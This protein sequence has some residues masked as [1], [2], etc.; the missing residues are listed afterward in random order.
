M[1]KSVNDDVVQ[2]EAREGARRA[3]SA[4]NSITLRVRIENKVG[5]IGEVIS[6]IGRAGGDVGAIDIVQVTG[7][8]VI[9][10]ITV[11]TSSVEHGEQIVDFVGELPGIEVMH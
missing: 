5:M 8:H 4:S 9:R 6:A 7:A 11:D 3:P 1:E 10:D 2:S